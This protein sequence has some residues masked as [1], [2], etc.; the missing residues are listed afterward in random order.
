M[1]QNTRMKNRAVREIPGKIMHTLVRALLI[2]GALVS[3]AMPAG[4]ALEGPPSL[5]PSLHPHRAKCVWLDVDK[6]PVLLDDEELLEFL[7]VAEATKWKKVGVG[8][9]KISKVLLEKNGVRLHAAWRVVEVEIS[10]FRLKDGSKLLRLRDS[11]LFEVA[12][13]RLSRI[14]GLRN[15]PPA[16]LREFGGKVGTLQLWLEDTVT[17]KDLTGKFGTPPQP[18]VWAYQN[19]TMH[20]FDSLVCNVDRNQGNLL[21][22]QDWRL[23]LIDHTRA[24]QRS[25]ECRKLESLRFFDREVFSRFK[26]LDE[27]TVQNEMKGLLKAGEIKDL[28]IRRDK[29]VT[30]IEDLIAEKGEGA[31]LF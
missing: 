7:R 16:V 10:N 24:F 27:D 23:W 28:M 15:I 12:A 8:I 31:V 25:W 19:S 2:G 21:I 18:I 4:A 3:A 6:K 1:T 30:Y 5:T 9:N 13:Y 14:L 29:I 20:M 22:D 26:Q 11:C 17:Q